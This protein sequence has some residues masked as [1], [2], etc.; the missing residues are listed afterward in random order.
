MRYQE[1]AKQ[2]KN[3]YLRDDQERI[4]MAITKFVNCYIF[5]SVFLRISRHSG[6]ETPSYSYIMVMMQVMTNMMFKI[7]QEQ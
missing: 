6:C 4:L 7:S 3:K 2:K 5:T 1:F